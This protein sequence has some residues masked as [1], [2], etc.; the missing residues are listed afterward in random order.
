MKGEDGPWG[1]WSEVWESCYFVS[2]ENG[3]TSEEGGESVSEQFMQ[4]EK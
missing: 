3:S 1:G 2:L 4:M